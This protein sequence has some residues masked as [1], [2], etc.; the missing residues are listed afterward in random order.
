[1]NKNKLWAAG[2]VLGLTQIWGVPALA[3]AIDQQVKHIPIPLL[4]EQ[5]KHVLE[6]GKPYSPRTS[7]GTAGCHDYDA[8]THAYH[9]ETGR[10]EAHDDYGE[11]IGLPQLVSPGYFGG[12]NCMG[13]NNP[14]LL[15]KKS[16]P[17]EADFG[18]Y[19]S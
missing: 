9:F 16:N 5:G 2:L 7:C 1:M 11:K 13:G 12:Y 14:D 15:A 8:I 10:D 3:N 19:G 18:D 6:S 4:D 17:T